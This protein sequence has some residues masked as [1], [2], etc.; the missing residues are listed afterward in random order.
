MWSCGCWARNALSAGGL[1]PVLECHRHRADGMLDYLSAALV[2]APLARHRSTESPTRRC[3]HLQWLRVDL[4][5]GA[6]SDVY[7]QKNQSG[8]ARGHRRP[9]DRLTPEESSPRE[10]EPARSIANDTLNV[11]GYAPSARG[12]SACSTTISASCIR[13]TFC[14]DASPNPVPSALCSS[15][16]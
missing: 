13:A 9:R 14:A 7:C 8:D 3:R 11:V 12:C 10:S 16:A 6:S 5:S 2:T 15:A 1:V 4:H